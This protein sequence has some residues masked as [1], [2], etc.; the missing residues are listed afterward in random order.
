MPGSKEDGEPW[1]VSQ[2]N[3]SGLTESSSIENPFIEKDN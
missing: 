3:F 2:L 1:Y